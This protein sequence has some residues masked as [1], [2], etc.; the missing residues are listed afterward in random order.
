MDRWQVPIS[1]AL[2]AFIVIASARERHLNKVKARQAVKA[3][4][5]SLAA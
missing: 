5:S 3:H 1:M 2:V 4:L